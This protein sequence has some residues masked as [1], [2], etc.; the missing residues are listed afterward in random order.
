MGKPTWWEWPFD[1]GNL[2]LRER[3]GQRLFSET[4]LREMLEAVLMIRLGD[5]PNR[6][7]V[8]ARY[9]GRYWKIVVEPDPLNQIVVGVT[10]FNVGE[11]P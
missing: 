1:C 5:L 10:A 8:Y 6:Y 3:M 2:H 9:D 11:P 4:D 7:N